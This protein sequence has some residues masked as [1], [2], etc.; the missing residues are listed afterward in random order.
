M[1]RNTT[2]KTVF[3]GKFPGSAGKNGSVARARFWFQFVE[4][5]FRNHIDEHQLNEAE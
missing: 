2:A 5:M 1:L 3:A 4:T